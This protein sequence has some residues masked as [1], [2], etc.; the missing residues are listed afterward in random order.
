LRQHGIEGRAR[1]QQADG[2]RH[3]GLATSQGLGQQH[4]RFLERFAH[5]RHIQ[6]G[7][8][9]AV[10]LGVVQ[11]GVQHVGRLVQVQAG[12]E[13]GVR[14]IEL[15]A[16]EHIGPAQHVRGAMPTHQQ[17]LG[18][19][20]DVAQHDDRGGMPRRRVDRV[21]VQFHGGSVSPVK[22]CGFGARAEG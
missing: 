22:S 18:P 1:L 20:A 9:R 19:G 14:R 21:Q 12:V 13:L 2:L 16:G 10:Q 3:I 5:G 7:G 15:A 11:A 8:A 17:H 4:T 6:A